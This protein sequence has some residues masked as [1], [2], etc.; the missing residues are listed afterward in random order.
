[1][2]EGKP[3][4]LILGL[5]SVPPELLFDRFLPQMPSIQRLMERG[6]YGVLRTIDPPITVPAWAVMFTGV[7]PGTL[8]IYG[9]RHR[10]PGSYTDTYVPNPRMIRFPPVWDQLSRAGKR[11][12]VIGMPPGYPPPTVNG[13]YIGDFLTPTKAKDFVDFALN[14]E[15]AVEVTLQPIRRFGMDGAILFADIL[16]LPHALG[17]KL[18]FVQGEGPR[19]HGRS[20]LCGLEPRRH[21]RIRAGRHDLSQ[22]DSGEVKGADQR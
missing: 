15:L 11:V 21:R 6:P 10:R 7:D 9:F 5:D 20:H 19:D 16:L 22:P 14:P 8:G 2:T 13:V 1:M 4:L 3:R 18:E 12:C 17:Q